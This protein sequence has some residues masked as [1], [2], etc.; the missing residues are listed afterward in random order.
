[1]SEIGPVLVA[2]DFLFLGFLLVQVRYLPGRSELVG[3]LTGLSYA[4]YARR[5]FFEL[6]TVAALILPLLLVAASLCRWSG[7]S[8]VLLVLVAILQIPTR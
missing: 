4:E 1:M 3:A 7:V 2:V 8:A 6:V 5:G